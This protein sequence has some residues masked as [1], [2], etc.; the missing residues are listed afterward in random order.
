MKS[1]TRPIEGAYKH[2]LCKTIIH[3]FECVLVQIYIFT[4]KAGLAVSKWSGYKIHEIE[5]CCVVVTCVHKCKWARMNSHLLDN[6]TRANLHDELLITLLWPL[7]NCINAE[8]NVF[9]F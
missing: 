9:I 6:F 2:L 7:E 5:Y 1:T 4:F 3:T 8:K